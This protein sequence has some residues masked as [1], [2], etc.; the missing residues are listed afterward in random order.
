ML[1]KCSNMVV[2][3]RIE[4]KK[5]LVYLF[6]LIEI[7]HSSLETHVIKIINLSTIISLETYP[8]N[9]ADDIAHGLVVVS[10]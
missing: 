2:L 10:E 4:L 9:R 1:L 8:H 5:P 7:N 6:R 3:N